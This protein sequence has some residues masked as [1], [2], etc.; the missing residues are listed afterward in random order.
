MVDQLS[1]VVSTVEAALERGGA[2]RLTVFV[3]LDNS[4]IPAV[5][6][7]AQQSRIREQVA[8]RTL[9]VCTT[10]RLAK[11]INP[12]YTKLKA[13]RHRSNILSNSIGAVVGAGGISPFVLVGRL[14]QLNQLDL[15]FVCP[16]CQGLHAESSLITFC[17]KC[18]EQCNESALRACKRCKFDFRGLASTK[19]LW[20]DPIAPPTTAIPSIPPTQW[21]PPVPDQRVESGVTTPSAPSPAPAW[22]PPEAAHRVVTPPNWY[23]DPVGKHQFRWWDGSTWTANALDN[24]VA[25]VD[26]L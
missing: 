20:D 17:P 18:G 14:A 19:D 26:S 10:C 1:G 15:E 12:D 21:A 16:R 4:A 7:L 24:G 23:P 13:K 8:V 11:V 25:T 6:F 2:S 22:S 9:Q 3:E 5:E